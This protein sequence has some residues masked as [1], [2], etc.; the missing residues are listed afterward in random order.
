MQVLVALGGFVGWDG[1]AVSAPFSSLA[2]RISR[3]GY[4]V[5]TFTWDRTQDMYGFIEAC[6]DPRLFLIGY[7]GGAMSL[8]YVSAQTHKPIDCIVCYDPSPRRQLTPVHSNVKKVLTYE[9]SAPWFFGYGGGV[10][11]LEKGNKTT[12][13][14]RVPIAENH[15][16][17]QSDENLHKRTF[18]EIARTVG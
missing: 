12:V 1:L 15:S 8:L 4:K 3:Q 17:V 7:S 13:I 2:G 16:V 11:T 18:Q 5:T 10:V 6:R 9:N 14:E